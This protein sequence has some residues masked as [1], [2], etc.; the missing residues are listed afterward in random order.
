M[1]TESNFSKKLSTRTKKY[2]NR[3]STV[4]YIKSCLI[5][6]FFRKY[7]IYFKMEEY[8]T[9]LY[10]QNC[11]WRAVG[12]QS[13]KIPLIFYSKKLFACHGAISCSMPSDSFRWLSSFIV[14]S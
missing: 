1:S 3:G 7:S 12:K 6:L 2:K 14:A 10:L 9:V 13:L 11:I 8:S 4:Q 5:N